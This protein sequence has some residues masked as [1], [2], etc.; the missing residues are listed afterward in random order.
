[1]NNRNRFSNLDA[2]RGIASIFVAFQHFMFSR[3]NDT[4]IFNKIIYVLTDTLLVGKMGVTIFFCIS[5]FVI[6]WSLSRSTF[7]TFWIARFFRLYPIYWFSILVAVSLGIMV[8]NDNFIAI[9]LAN[10]TMLQGYLGYPHL[11][12]V[13]WTLGIELAFYVFV[14]LVFLLNKL[15]DLKFIFNLS[16]V[17]LLVA[18]FL[19][20]ARFYIGKQLPVVLP[21][22]MSLMFW[23]VLV[24]MLLVDQVDGAKNKVIIFLLIFLLVMPVISML[25]Y[26]NTWKDNTWSNYTYC[27]YLAVGIFLLVANYR[28]FTNPITV[29]LGKISY[30]IYLFHIL[31]MKYFE[32]TFRY[33][34]TNFGMFAMFLAYMFILI[35]LSSLTYFLI[36]KPAIAAGKKV[37]KL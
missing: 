36:E 12:G 25:A 23:S 14:S 29:Y 5:G 7:K 21:L 8:S 11:V 31:V 16:L 37:I 30:S 13:Y 17:F 35:T 20:I 26:M 28:F 2:L 22:A 4:T 24:K 33:L 15:D 9:L 19:A 10:L 1:M 27:Y 18:V 34:E 3:G 32:S 6:S